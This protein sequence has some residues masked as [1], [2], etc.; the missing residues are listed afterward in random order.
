MFEA[1]H[2]GNLKPEFTR[3]ALLIA[4][5]ALAGIAILALRKS[6]D[7]EDSGSAGES[8]EEGSIVEFDDKGHKLGSLRVKKVVRSSSEWRKQLNAEQY[9]VT[10]QQGTDVA[11]SGTYYQFHQEGIF[12]SIPAPAGPVFGHP[13][14]KRTC[15]PGPISVC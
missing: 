14:P 2:P 3:R 6:R 7:G 15:G 13:S 8:A 5:F 4:P 11:F 12:R 1:L 10:R 9:Y